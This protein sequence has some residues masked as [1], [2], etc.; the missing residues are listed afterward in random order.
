MPSTFFSLFAREVA[1]E[2]ISNGPAVP[3]LAASQSADGLPTIGLL[4]TPELENVIAECKSQ[5]ARIAKS[6]KMRNTR[7]RDPDF[8]LLADRGRCLNGLVVAEVYNPSDVQ[9]VTELFQDAEFFSDSPYSNEIIQGNSANCWFISSLAATSTVKGLVEKYCV[10]RDEEVGVYGFVFWREVRWTSVI[11]D[12]LLFTIV[13]RYEELSIPEKAL[14]QNDKDKYIASAPKGSHTLYF[15]RSGKVG[16]TWVS[17]VEKAYAKLHGDYGS[18]CSGYAG[19]AAEDLTGGVSSFIQIRDILDKDRFWKEELLKAN[20]DRIFACSFHTLSPVRNGDLNATIN[21]LRSK[22]S[23]AVLKTL[24][25]R[26]EALLDGS[27]EWTAEWIG[28]L[29]LLGHVFGDSGKFI[30]EYKDFLAC[31]AKIDRTRLFDSTWTMTYQ[32]LRVPSR[33]FPGSGF[34]YGDLCFSFSLS[35]TGSAVIVLSQLDVRYFRGLVACD[36]NFDFVLYR[37]GEKEPIDASSHSAVLSRSIGLEFPELEQGDYIV[38]CRLDRVQ[39]SETEGTWSNSKLARVVSERAKSESIASNLKADL[40]VEDLPIPLDILAG[41]DLVDLSRKALDF[42]TNRNKLGDHAD[43][44]PSVTEV[45][46]RS[47]QIPKF[48]V[49]DPNTTKT[50]TTITTLRAPSKVTTDTREIIYFGPTGDSPPNDDDTIPGD[51]QPPENSRPSSPVPCNTPPTDDDNCVFLGLKVYTAKDVSVSITG[52]LRHDMKASL[53][54]LTV[55]EWNSFS[56]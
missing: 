25:Y 14:F 20:K 55:A 46:L 6:C 44:K 16:E 17:L 1:P 34:G 36:W 12:D 38:H 22:H 15:S 43:L 32:V 8:D 19:E 2:P 28:M 45:Q 50:I 35:K 29:P 40:E 49:E 39:F 18:M 54:G 27:K 5:V 3:E 4:S 37:R 24:E 53:E 11:I 31:F 52:Q 21:G 9:R 10:A 42:K 41:Q 26:G 47:K 23:Y 7:Y 51:V 33:P 48:E 30:V 56:L 13:P